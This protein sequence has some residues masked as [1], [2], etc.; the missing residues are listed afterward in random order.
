MRYLIDSDWAIAHL[1]GRDGVTR[2]INELMPQGIGISIISVA[3]L[4]EGVAHSEHRRADELRLRRFL[5]TV[6]IVSLNEPI[7]EL[8][9]Q[10]RARLRTTGKLIGDLDLLIGCT[11]VYSGLTLLTNN[12][13]HFA[14]IADIAIVSN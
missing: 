8:F 7:C 5:D 9:G 12:R 3:E 4:F 14:R 11:A 10:E 6:E 13:R 1:R 2:R